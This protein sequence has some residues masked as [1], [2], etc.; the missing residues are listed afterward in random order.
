VPQYSFIY[1]PAGDGLMM[2]S[3]V[4]VSHRSWRVK[5]KTC[6]KGAMCAICARQPMF[7]HT[8]SDFPQLLNPTSH[9]QNEQDQEDQT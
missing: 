1:P 6:E 9:Q 7:S 4:S 2:S 3:I 8:S 5:R